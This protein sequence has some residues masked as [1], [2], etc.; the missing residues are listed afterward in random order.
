MSIKLVDKF[1]RE[2]VSEN[3]IKNMQP[4]ADAAFNL[5]KE[6]NGHGSDF[7]GWVD[8]PI[9]YDKD[10]FARIEIAAEKIKKS[11]DILVVI[12]IGGSYLGA[13]AA[14]EFVNSPSQQSRPH[15]HTV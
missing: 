1:I 10:E 2:F 3:E 13:R 15:L 7:L 14:I 9:N 6:K 4:D 11:C 12:G 5:I 8:L